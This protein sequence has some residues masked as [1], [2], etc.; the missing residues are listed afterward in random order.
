MYTLDNNIDIFMT[1][2]LSLNRKHYRKHY[3]HI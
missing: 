2:T 1:S 3:K